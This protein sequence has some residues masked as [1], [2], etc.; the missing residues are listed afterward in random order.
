MTFRGESGQCAEGT[1]DVEP[2]SVAGANLADPDEIV[3]GAYSPY[4]HCR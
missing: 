4:P 2:Q 1:V 3:D